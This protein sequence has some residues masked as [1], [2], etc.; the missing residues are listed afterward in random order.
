M[1]DQQYD[2][3]ASPMVTLW[4]NR[5]EAARSIIEACNSAEH[6]LQP[7][8]LQLLPGQPGHLANKSLYVTPAGSSIYVT[9]LADKIFWHKY[10]KKMTFRTRPTDLYYAACGFVPGTGGPLLRLATDAE[11]LAFQDQQ[12]QERRRIERLEIQRKKGAATFSP[13]QDKI[14]AA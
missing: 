4:V 11:I 3:N 1:F 6:G 12:L 5:Y 7:K 14:D 9:N 13:D 8:N 10:E 2:P